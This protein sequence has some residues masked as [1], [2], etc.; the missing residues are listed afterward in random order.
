[1]IGGAHSIILP[2]LV[3]DTYLIAGLKEISP[4]AS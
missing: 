4:V 1:M 3:K 2:W